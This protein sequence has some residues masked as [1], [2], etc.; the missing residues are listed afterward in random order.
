MQ[1][2]N[3]LGFLNIG[4]IGFFQFEIKN[5]SIYYPWQRIL[6]KPGRRH[7]YLHQTEKAL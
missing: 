5:I 1:P 6:L 4:S 7:N 2:M 3:K